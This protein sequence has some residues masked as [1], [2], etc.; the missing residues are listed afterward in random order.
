MSSAAIVLVLL[1]VVAGC[2]T[3]CGERVLKIPRDLP[4][5]RQVVGVILIWLGIKVTIYTIDGLKALFQA[6]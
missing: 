6:M 1:L 5:W 4:M 3:V 2:I